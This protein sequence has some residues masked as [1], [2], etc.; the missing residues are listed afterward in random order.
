MGRV[1]PPLFFAHLFTHPDFGKQIFEL[2]QPP[3]STDE[4]YRTFSLSVSAGFRLCQTGNTLGAPGQIIAQTGAEAV[5][6]GNHSRRIPIP[7]VRSSKRCATAEDKLSDGKY[8]FCLRLAYAGNW[9]IQLAISTMAR[10][11]ASAR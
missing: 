9:K 5:I 7:A 3:L 10:P 4:S 8:R 2:T 11:P 6:P 1:A